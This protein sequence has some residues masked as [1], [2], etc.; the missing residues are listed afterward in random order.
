MNFELEL[1]R[2]FLNK[3]LNKDPS[4]FKNISVA[5]IHPYPPGI[6]GLRNRSR[7]HALVQANNDT[8]GGKW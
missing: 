7:I 4:V 8:C 3:D 6:K 5:E 2:T 1:K